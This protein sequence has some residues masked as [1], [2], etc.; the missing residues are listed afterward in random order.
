MSRSGSSDVRSQTPDRQL[1]RSQEPP[2]RRA[3][4]PDQRLNLPRGEQREPVAFRG[5][6][7]RLRGSEVRALATVGAFR[8]VPAADLQS[9]G[10]QGDRWHGDL[11]ALRQQGLKP[12][13]L[14]GVGDLGRQPCDVGDLLDHRVKG[15]ICV[16]W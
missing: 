1:P 7:Y 5:R 6:T 3:Q 13:E 11:A 12:V 16:I 4:L 9:S 10:V 14:F 8:V 15:R 2:D